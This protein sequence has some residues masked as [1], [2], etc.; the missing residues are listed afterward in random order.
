[1]I[2]PSEQREIEEFARKLASGIGDIVK[3]RYGRGLCFTLLL[4]TTGA[5]GWMTYISS[6][7]RESMVQTLREL[8]AKVESDPRKRAREY[9]KEAPVP[10]RFNLQ[11]LGA[12]V[13]K[14]KGQRIV[15]P[16]LPGGESVVV[17]ANGRLAGVL[18][19]SGAEERALKARL[20]GEEEGV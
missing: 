4:A 10:Q 17:T 18:V 12:L 7:E 15:I 9:V 20:F 3:E 14:L 1:M 13:A 16:E 5:D 11:R 8:A 19:L 6:A 2:S